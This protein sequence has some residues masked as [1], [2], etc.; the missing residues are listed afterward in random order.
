MSIIV[1]AGHETSK[2]KQVME[3]LYERGLGR[4]ADSYTHK[5][6]PQQVSEILYKVL[7][8]EHISLADEKIAD[9]I[10]TDFLLAN[11]DAENWGWETS[12]NLFSLDYWQQMDPSIGF[13]FVF[14]NPVHLLIA[15]EDTLLTVDLVDNAMEEWIQYHQDMLSLIEKYEDNVILIEGAYAIG[16]I[17]KLSEPVKLIASTLHLKSNWQVSS[18]VTSQSGSLENNFDEYADVAIGHI[19]NEILRKYPEAIKIFKL[20]LSKASVKSSEPIYKTKQADLDSLLSALKYLNRNKKNNFEI[21]ENQN[22]LLKKELEATDLERKRVIK[23]NLVDQK[24]INQYKT[25]LD[26]LQEV[27]KRSKSATEKSTAIESLKKENDMLIK[28]LHHIQEELEK[29]YLKNQGYSSPSLD[30]KNADQQKP[31][32]AVYSGA[33]ERVKQDLPYRLGATMV[34]KSK[35]AKDLATLPLSLAKEYNR[36]KKSNSNQQPLPKMEEYHD[37]HEGEK[38]KNQLSYKLGKVLLEGMSSPKAFV[39]LPFRM[40]KETIEFKK[41]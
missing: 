30:E 37:I 16:N 6:T 10:M 18:I 7:S 29:Y 33:A 27:D 25:E 3:K 38:V 24:L 28:Q 14:D 1:Q 22:K 11:L 15:L 12:K 21:L 4:P 32:T 2:S 36:F 19:S 31:K 23:Q 26:H 35:T 39:Q 41:K 5:M 40:S 9:N 20:L 34:N 17:S 8:Q 13:I